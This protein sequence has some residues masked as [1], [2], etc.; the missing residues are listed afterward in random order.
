MD[1]PFQNC[2]VST[3]NFSVQ[4]VRKLLQFKH[5]MTCI[6]FDLQKFQEEMQHLGEKNVVAHYLSGLEQDYV[7]RISS[8]KRK[9][10]W[11]G[12][13]FVAKYAA[14][15][16]LVQKGKALSW[17]KLSVIADENGRPFLTADKENEALPDISISHSGGLAAALAVSKGLSG[18]DIQ[19]VTD[20]V[21]K[22]SDRFCTPHEEYILRTFFSTSPEKQSSLLT[23]LW[24]AKETLRKVANTKYLPGFLELELAEIHT[25]FA[26]KN[27]SPWRFTFTWNHRDMDGNQVTEK[28][29]AAVTLLADYALA[30]T[31]RNDSVG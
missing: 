20:R 27:S 22:V 11:L 26:D 28:C 6:L 17:S 16:M 7:N 3:E 19:K 1:F 10:E 21:I 2:L 4:Q 15:E 14:A 24:A 31:A 25:L 29:S 8:D 18:I 9:R 12:G 13:R 5:G 23:K 30:L